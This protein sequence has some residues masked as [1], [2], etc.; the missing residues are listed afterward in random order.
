MSTVTDALKRVFARNTCPVDGTD[1]TDP[2]VTRHDYGTCSPEC[3]DE[4]WM[5]WQY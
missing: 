2:R 3:A 5:R 4:M 1:L